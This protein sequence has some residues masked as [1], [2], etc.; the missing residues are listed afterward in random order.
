[1]MK[2]F[3]VLALVSFMN[4][5]T[6]DN[7][8][9]TLGHLTRNSRRNSEKQTKAVT[10]LIERI[11]PQHAKYFRVVVNSSQAENEKEFFRLKS[12][13]GTIN[14][15]ATTGVAAA[16]GFNHYLKYFCN[17]HIS[18]RTSQLNLP[19]TLPSVDIE[20]KFNDRFRYYQN[21]C[22]TSYS[23]VW[24]NWKKWEEHIDWM[25]MNS[26]NLV[27][28]FNGQEA[29]WTK[30]YQE[31]GLSQDDIDEFFTGP[32][33]LSWLRMGNVRKW[34]GP[35][36]KSWH[37]RSLTLQ[38]QIVTRLRSF[39]VVTVL[40]AFAGHL[41]RA[42]KRL[43]PKANMVKLGSWNGFNDTY[44]CPYFLDPT[45]ELFQQIGKSF[46]QK[47]VA[48]YGT[49]N[50]YSCDSF[51]ENTPPSTD[52]HY[53][54]NVSS[55]IYRAMTS[56]DPK[57]V[58]LMQNW[59]FVHDAPYWTKDR[60]KALLTSVPKGKMIVLDLQSEQFP[61][62]ASLDQYFGQP[63]I[64]C[65]LHNFGG[66]LGI[67]GN[68]DI[69]N[70][71]PIEARTAANSTMIG[72]G[73]T[74]EGINQNYVV[75]ELMTEAAWRKEPANLTKWFGDYSTRR[76]GYR[77]DSVV[78]SWQYFQKTIYNLKSLRRMRGQY[79]LTRTPSWSIK[80]WAWYDTK[81]YMLTIGDFLDGHYVMPNIN[82]AFCHD[83]IDLLRQAHQI[84]FDVVYNQMK[85]SFKKKDL[86]LFEIQTNSSLFLLINVN[87]FLK[88]DTAFSL[89]EWVKSARDAGDT[90]EEKDW[91]EYNARNQIT[92]WGP[93]GEI[94]NY[95]IKQWS[96]VVSDF[97][98]PRWK[99]FLDYSHDILV[100]N[101]TF[102]DTYIK[103]KMFETAEEPFTFKKT[104]T[105]EESKEE[106]NYFWT[107]LKQKKWWRIFETYGREKRKSR[108]N[109]YKLD[110]RAMQEFSAESSF[111]DDD[112][113][114]KMIR[115]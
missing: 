37:E 110:W 87:N 76:Y 5:C 8:E 42:F 44:C 103:Q 95:A 11:L 112:I 105:Y 32:A 59:L 93:K 24:W 3:I 21:V 91:F 51:N 9:S 23:F 28:A 114:V 74:M 53:L 109:I 49:D 81:E 10:D 83:S 7:F 71:R 79:T 1:M 111:V 77:V 34:G 15:Y 107:E 22:T 31:F 80:P 26:F 64:W 82:Y 56:A 62:Y 17:C 33:F 2:F 55:S 73:L 97:I 100:T 72:T 66:T 88:L 98:Y 50:I 70:E 12:D 104:K 75:Y 60:A 41:P 20:I 30:V 65:M 6:G 99:V 89:D 115:K 16:S 52:L 102:N 40:P 94:M 84:M 57:A 63:Y 90:P 92:L 14:I 43:Y 27:L 46:I 61:Q 106:C 68:S 47:Q 19:K 86:T 78:K 25:V 108:N 48:E 35:L 101:G 113:E 58:W 38:K 67:F 39:G 96:G 13:N 54:A 85:T 45:E 4:G 69:I 18:W 36:S 29:I